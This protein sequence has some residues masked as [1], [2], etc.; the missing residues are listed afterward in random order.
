[1]PTVLTCAGC[2]PGSQQDFLAGQHHFLLWLQEEQK[3]TFL[4]FISW[5]RVQPRGVQLL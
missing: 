4:S 1:M 2:P 5:L 3:A